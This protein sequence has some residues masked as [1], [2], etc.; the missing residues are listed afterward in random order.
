MELRA[1][2][3][4]QHK[5]MQIIQR[6]TVDRYE[7]GHFDH[8]Y[9]TDY[10]IVCKACGYSVCKEEEIDAKLA[11]NKDKPTLQDLKWYLDHG[12]MFAEKWEKEQKW[13]EKNGG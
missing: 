13:L 6:G 2:P 7:D 4:C 9:C 10:R 5:A 11:W 3:L 8:F 1:C 12:Y